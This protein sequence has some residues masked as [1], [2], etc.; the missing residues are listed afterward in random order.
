MLKEN[1]PSNK[2]VCEQLGYTAPKFEKYFDFRLAKLS[3]TLE[4]HLP[5]AIEEKITRHL[6]NDQVEVEYNDQPTGASY[7]W[8]VKF[9][10]GYRLPYPL[11]NLEGTNSTPYAHGTIEK[12]MDQ[13]DEIIV[14]EKIISAFYETR[15]EL[16]QAFEKLQSKVLDQ[17][18]KNRLP[19]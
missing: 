9:N 18:E 6:E 14:K 1:F 17:N 12:T 4:N 15:P 5:I 13:M 19:K 10:N 7:F 16:K 8:L 3:K 11:M 2:S